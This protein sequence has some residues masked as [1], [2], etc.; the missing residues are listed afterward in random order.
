MMMFI[1]R[2]KI[3]WRGIWCKYENVYIDMYMKFSGS[4]DSSKHVHVALFQNVLDVY[5]ASK[6]SRIRRWVPNTQYYMYYVR[7]Q[8]NN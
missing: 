7:T 6:N 8:V 4:N 3:K 1:V 5:E 2:E